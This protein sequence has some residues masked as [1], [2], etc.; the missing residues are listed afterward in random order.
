[1][2]TSVLYWISERLLEVSY[3]FADRAYD[4]KDAR[5]YIGSPQDDDGISCGKGCT[6]ND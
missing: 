3:F 6:L 5:C 2:I 1:M 4:I